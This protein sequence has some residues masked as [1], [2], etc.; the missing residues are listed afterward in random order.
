LVLPGVAIQPVRCS[1]NYANP[2]LSQVSDFEHDSLKPALLKTCFYQ[3][4][5]ERQRKMPETGAADSQLQLQQQD[6][7]KV[8]RNP[9]KVRERCENFIVGIPNNTS[10]LLIQRYSY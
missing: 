10:N 9:I 5:C 4:W 2:A 6:A 3:Y 8:S 7:P 1:S